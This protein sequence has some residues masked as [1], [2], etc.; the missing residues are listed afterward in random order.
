MLTKPYLEPQVL[1]TDAPGQ[2]GNATTVHGLNQQIRAAQPYCSTEA[3]KCV[4][5]SIAEGRL[6][7]C[8]GDVETDVVLPST[9]QL[10]YEARGVV[11]FSSM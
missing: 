10:V 11:R 9:L 3:L 4:V 6:L 2:K 7:A 8:H 5:R 1:S